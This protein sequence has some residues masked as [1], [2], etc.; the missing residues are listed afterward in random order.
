ME[1]DNKKLKKIFFFPT[2]NVRKE[3]IWNKSISVHDDW[4]MENRKADKF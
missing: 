3:K 2:F 4:Y 1:C